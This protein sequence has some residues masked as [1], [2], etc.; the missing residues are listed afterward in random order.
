MRAL[1]R[2]LARA[3]VIIVHVPRGGWQASDAALACRPDA[4]GTR[5]SG[6]EQ[7]SLFRCVE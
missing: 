6:R 3:H 7:T 1:P 4:F 2:V 5:G